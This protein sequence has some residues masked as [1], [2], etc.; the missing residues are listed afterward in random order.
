MP[1]TKVKKRRHENN[2]NPP[3]LLTTGEACRILCIHG[4]TLRRWC[5]RGLIVSYRIGPRGD[6]RFKRED[7][8]A[9]LVEVN[10]HG[11]R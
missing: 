3:P 2:G 11:R 5:Q 9:L 1:A 8:V 7:V 10:K 6:R 4:N